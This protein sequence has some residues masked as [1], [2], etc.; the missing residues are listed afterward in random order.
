MSQHTQLSQ[1]NGAS[2]EDCHTNFFSLTDL[3]GIKWRVYTWESNSTSQPPF[4]NVSETVEDPVLSSYARCLSSDVLCVWRRSWRRPPVLTDPLLD[5][6]LPPSNTT[7]PPNNSPRNQTSLK[8]SSKQ[9]WVFWYGEEPDL[10]NLVAPELSKSVK[11]CRL[12]LAG[13]T[14]QRT[15]PLHELAGGGNDPDLPPVLLACHLCYRPACHLSYRPAC[16]LS[17]RPACH[18]CYRPACHLCYWPVTCVAGLPATC[19]TGLPATRVA[20]LPATRVAG[21]P[22]TRVAGLPAT[23]VA[24]LPCVHTTEIYDED[25]TKY[26]YYYKN[27][28]RVRL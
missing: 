14:V 28:T 27:C 10:S 26:N 18:L 9:L 19:V 20:G 24:S 21:L 17:Y 13:V 25:A 6:A 2:L 12:P 23:R 7:S 22:A 11:Q 16:H 8:H 3:V 1:T 15:F 5:S 4:N